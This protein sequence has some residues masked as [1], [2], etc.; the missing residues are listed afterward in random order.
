MEKARS[1]RHPI[2]YVMV[3][4]GLCEEETLKENPDEREGCELCRNVHGKRTTQ[5]SS[6]PDW[7]ENIIKDRVLQSGK[8]LREN[9]RE[10]FLAAL[11]L[12]EWPNSFP[13]AWI[14][15]NSPDSTCKGPGVEVSSICLR[16]IGR[17]GRRSCR[18]LQAFLGTLI[19][20]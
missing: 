18:A 17:R 12:L 16:K 19:S 14:P 6:Q 8:E 20:E 15:F 7:S 13:R 4:A 1:E 3:W 2:L 9:P 10:R 5:V 11:P